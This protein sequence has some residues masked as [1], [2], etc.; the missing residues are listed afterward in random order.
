V[1]ALS[2]AEE[3]ATFWHVE[4]LG[5]S[6]AS[7]RGSHGQALQNISISEF[8]LHGLHLG[9]IRGDLADVVN[10]GDADISLIVGAQI[11]LEEGPLVDLR[12]ARGERPLLTL[13]LALLG[14]NQ[15]QTLEVLQQVNLGKVENLGVPDHAS[16]LVHQIASAPNLIRLEG[17]EARVLQTDIGHG[18]SV[19]LAE[20]RVERLV[21]ELFD[22]LVAAHAP[23]EA[24]EGKSCLHV[25]RRNIIRECLV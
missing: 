22:A 3:G 6:S 17:E 4:L 13:H 25:A 24:D 10:V 12:D 14:L 19:L 8:G 20:R 2:L 15:A 5:L 16:R 21:K 11:R 23:L 18:L 7:N 9:D 1:S